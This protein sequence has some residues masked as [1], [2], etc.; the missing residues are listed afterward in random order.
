MTVA[1]KPWLNKSPHV[2][3]LVLP[4]LTVHRMQVRSM[5]WFYWCQVLN[6]P[7]ACFSRRFISSVLSEPAPT[8][9]SYF[10]HWLR[11]WNPASSAVGAH[12]DLR[13]DTLCILRCFSAHHYYKELPSCLSAC[14]TAGPFSSNISTK[15]KKAFLVH[16][17]FFWGFLAPHWIIS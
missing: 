12:L 15:K 2:F 10:C 5:D 17:V 13:L 14:Q 11:E 16:D 4:A 8:A 3:I 9:A 7:S 1:F 6:P